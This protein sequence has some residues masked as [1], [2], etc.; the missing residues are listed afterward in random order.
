MTWLPALDPG[1]IWLGQAFHF[2]LAAVS[3]WHFFYQASRPPSSAPLAFLRSFLRKYCPTQ[4]PRHPISK[5]PR[6]NETHVWGQCDQLRH[7]T[8]WLETKWNTCLRSL[9]LWRHRTAWLETSCKTASRNS[10]YSKYYFIKKH[11]WWFSE[12]FCK[13]TNI[14]TI[15]DDSCR[16]WDLIFSL[17]HKDLGLT[18]CAN[19]RLDFTVHLLQITF[20]YLGTNGFS[21]KSSSFYWKW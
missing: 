11:V 2:A 14:G 15:L 3:R 1:P 20:S 19:T 4:P 21:R 5:S 12:G 16:F 17:F 6:W 7:R 8:T 13:W 18:H 10:M 9:S